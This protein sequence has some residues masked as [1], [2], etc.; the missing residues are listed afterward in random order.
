MTALVPSFALFGVICGGVLVLSCDPTPHSQEVG[1]V[2]QESS[3]A[4]DKE[5]AAGTPIVMPK[6][7]QASV[8]IRSPEEIENYCQA[9]CTKSKT[10][11]CS[12]DFGHCASMC[13]EM[14]L[15]P[16]C[17]G[18]MGQVL[19]CLAGLGDA[20]WQCGDEGFPEVL[21]GQCDAEQEAVLLCLSVGLK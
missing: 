16:E 9:I 6:K 17:R 18:E 7:V 8:S 3:A 5:V 1:E 2:K 11:G 10:R 20:H 21:P 15:E 14:T 19:E 13:R 12:T 4:Q